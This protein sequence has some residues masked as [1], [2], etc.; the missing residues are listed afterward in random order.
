LAYFDLARC[1]FHH[2]HGELG[3]TAMA[4]S[5]ALGIEGTPSG[6]LLHRTSVAL[7]GLELKERLSA[8]ARRIPDPFGRF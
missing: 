1:A 6:S 2:G 3:R 8:L 4:A 5:R 7:L